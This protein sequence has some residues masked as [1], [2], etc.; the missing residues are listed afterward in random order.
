MSNL[1]DNINDKLRNYE[2]EVDQDALWSALE[3]HVPKPEKKRRL[4]IIWFFGIGLFVSTLSVLLL[5]DKNFEGQ[6]EITPA[7]EFTN[8]AMILAENQ[9][10]ENDKQ[11]DSEKPILKEE[12][13]VNKHKDYKIT[14]IQSQEQNNLSKDI[15]EI[16]LSVENKLV[17]RA[18][19]KAISI[20]KHS[21]MAE[22]DASVL[23]SGT[24]DVAN[25][26]QLNFVDSASLDFQSERFSLDAQIEPL[27]INQYANR[28]WYEFALG[29]G[30]TRTQIDQGDSNLE[31][32]V[33]QYST[34]MPTFSS[35][36]SLG[37][38]LNSKWSV[39]SGLDYQRLT[40][41]L[42]IDEELISTEI[43]Q[44][45]SQVIILPNGNEVEVNG[46]IT[47]T[48]T[49]QYQARQHSYFHQIGI[50]VGLEYQLLRGKRWNLQAG[51]GCT[52]LIAKSQVGGVLNDG[53][54]VNQFS[55]DSSPYSVSALS[56]FGYLGVQYKINNAWSI[57]LKPQGNFIQY[58]RTDR[59]I[60]YSH[61]NI[62]LN[63]TIRYR[64]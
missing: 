2:V 53:K 36:L 25:I 39:F 37:Y 54:K 26:S 12:Q 17:V 47:E 28:F 34:M 1:G 58:S 42:S 46:P 59:A 18:H 16:K 61:N 10:K 20:E 56:P 32:L 31:Y 33:D 45:V 4:L 63:F 35:H 11:L 15:S 60:L 30:V 64:Y 23:E 41:R 19:S 52:F 38:N 14:S 51:I 13:S 55:S 3:P 48:T 62:G 8:N 6:G 22:I 21:E 50:P 40:E 7:K 57:G 27:K 29:S 9:L 5:G 43:K 24:R 49:T 44:G